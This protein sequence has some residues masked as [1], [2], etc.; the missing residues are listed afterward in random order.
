MYV[1]L[2]R[3]NNTFVTVNVTT[4]ATAQPATA[5]AAAT[6]TAIALATTNNKKRRG[7]CLGDWAVAGGSRGGWL[8]ASDLLIFFRMLIFLMADFCCAT[9]K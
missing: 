9:Q 4:T 1:V 3:K 8:V 6:N 5:T 7:Q 2:S